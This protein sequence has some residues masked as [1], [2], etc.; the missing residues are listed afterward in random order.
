MKFEDKATMAKFVELVKSS[1]PLKAYRQVGLK[2]DDIKEHLTYL[3]EYE[4]I[5]AEPEEILVEPEEVLVE[6]PVEVASIVV[7]EEDSDGSEE[8]EGDLEE[9]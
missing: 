3:V 1:A 7:E 9:D 6:Q 5:L 4:R 2:K 8:E